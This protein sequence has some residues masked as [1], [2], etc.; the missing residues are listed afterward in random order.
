MKK[1][2]IILV[3]YGKSLDES[4]TFVSWNRYKNFL[5]AEYNFLIYNNDSSIK[6]PQSTDYEV[7]NS[8]TND[9]LQIPY[10]FALKKAVE[11]G[12][13]WL[14]LL[15][16]DTELT[17][18]F[19][20]ELSQKLDTDND[21]IV[22]MCFAGSR[23]ISPFIDLAKIGNY[24][25]SKKAKPSVTTDCV[26]AFNTCAMF[27]VDILQ[28]VGG[29]SPEFEFD[30]LD[31]HTFYKLYKNGAKIEILNT[32]IQHNLSI[33]DY[34]TLSIERYKSMLSAEKR[35]AKFVGKKAEFV[36]SIWLT[37]RFFKQLIVPYK[38][39]FAKITLKNL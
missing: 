1:I 19:F 12:C 35:F 9:K 24:F 22:P 10:S 33:L 11:T 3:L 37:L 31:I 14:L 28:K 29:F 27:S 30:F 21:A 23:Q 20:T 34:S 5:K 38:R 13:K 4:K 6:I 25:L 32:K 15:D 18:D 2:E 26:A 7:I 16:D 8:E 17:E 39:K 36:L